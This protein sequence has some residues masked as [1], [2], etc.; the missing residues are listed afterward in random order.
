MSLE[1]KKMLCYCPHCNRKE[2]IHRDAYRRMPK[3]VGGLELCP[4][5][6]EVEKNENINRV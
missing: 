1:M 4:K 2:C 6:K 3:E 5:F